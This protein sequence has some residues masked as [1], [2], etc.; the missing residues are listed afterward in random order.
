MLLSVQLR[1]AG[2]AL[3]Q[4]HCALRIDCSGRIRVFAHIVVCLWRFGHAVAISNSIATQTDVN[5]LVSWADRRKINR[6]HACRVYTQATYIS[7][8][9]D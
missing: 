3:R 6:Q 5:L 4:L 9:Y 1:S 7:F 8:A 2:T